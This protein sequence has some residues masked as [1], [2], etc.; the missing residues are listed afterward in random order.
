MVAWSYMNTKWP[1]FPIF[2][3][4]SS[5]HRPTNSN[6]YWRSDEISWMHSLRRGTAW[7][8]EDF[9]V[10]AILINSTFTCRT[11]VVHCVSK[12]TY[13]TIS[14]VGLTWKKDYLILAF[15][16]TNNADTTGHRTTVQFPTSS[17]VWFY[18][19]WEIQNKRNMRWNEQKTSTNFIYPDL[20]PRQPVD[21]KI[22]LSCSSESTRWRLGMLMNSRSDWW[23]LDWSEAEHYQHC[24]QRM[25]KASPC[26]RSR[27]GADISNIFT[28]DSWK[29]ENWMNCQPKCQKCRQNVLFWLSNNTAYFAGAV[30]HR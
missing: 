4:L 19:T 5:F 22:R 18:T 17:D 24:Y 8:N 7:T 25:E 6:Q 13:P 3:C 30:F 1:E 26:L 9:G 29:M 14:T 20:W 16:G 12:N 23:N 15:F 27:K 21:Y 11:A 2:G 10:L 28:V